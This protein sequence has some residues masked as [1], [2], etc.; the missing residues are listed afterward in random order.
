MAFIDLKC[1]SCNLKNDNTLVFKKAKLCGPEVQNS[2]RLKEEDY[3]DLDFTEQYSKI[4]GSHY[5]ARLS[6][7]GVDYL[8][9]GSI[10]FKEAYIKN[11]K[12]DI[13]SKMQNSFIRVY[14]DEHREH[15]HYMNFLYKS[16]IMPNG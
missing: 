9:D 10:C 11:F 12:F 6:W 1:E 13:Y 5:V 7:K 14:L 8:E 16:E 4:I 3:I 2:Y 15:N